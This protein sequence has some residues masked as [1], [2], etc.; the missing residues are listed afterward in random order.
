MC[1][2]TVVRRS[3]AL[4]LVVL[5]GCPKPDQTTTEPGGEP[6]GA[7]L[8]A[9]AGP[10]RRVSSRDHV[11]LDG[12]RSRG[13]SGAATWAWTQ[14]SGP[15]VAL[16]R[17]DSSRAEF[18]APEVTT[19]RVILTFELTLRDGAATA[20]TAC[21]VEVEPRTDS[22]GLTSSDLIRSAVDRGDLEPDTGIEY[23][24]FAVVGDA[25]LPAAYRGTNDRS[26]TAS[27]ARIRDEY[28]WLSSAA[29]SVVRPFLLPPSDPESWYAQ[30]TARNT[31]GPARAAAPPSTQGFVKV[32]G[33]HLNVWYDANIPDGATLAN[34]VQYE[35]ST[36][37]WRALEQLWAPD[38]RPLQDAG[39]VGDDDQIDVFLIST[40]ATT[41]NGWFSSLRAAPTPGF[42]VLTVQ[43]SPSGSLSSLG[44]AATLVHEL[45]HACQYSY[46]GMT[47]EL[48]MFIIEGTATWAKDFVYPR[49]DSTLW[50]AASAYFTDSRQYP[51]L[52]KG[53]STYGFYVLFKYMASVESPDFVRRAV[54][55]LAAAKAFDSAGAFARAFDPSVS[56]EER[57]GDFLVAAWNGDDTGY[58]RRDGL[59]VG[60]AP[61]TR[62]L[63]ANARQQAGL[64][65]TEFP[66]AIINSF[67]SV[68]IELSFDPGIRAVVFL[69]GLQ[70]ESF[71][72][73]DDNGTVGFSFRPLTP[74]ASEGVVTRVLD[75]NSGYWQERSLKPPEPA[76]LFC[77]EDPDQPTDAVG[78]IFG[79]ASRKDTIVEAR[80]HPPA[81]W[82]TNIGCYQ[83]QG[84]VTGEAR[85]GG[86]VFRTT[87]DVVFTRS[88]TN[89][90][91]D[92][93]L[94][95][96]LQ[97]AKVQWSIE[98]TDDAGCVHSGHD[99][100]TF[101]SPQS[102]GLEIAIN[103]VSGPDHRRYWING[104]EITA[105]YTTTC[106][107]SP[108]PAA[109]TL[110]WG[111]G[112]GILGSDGTKMVDIGQMNLEWSFSWKLSAKS[113]R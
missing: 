20:T 19:G 103:T 108:S 23:L 107:G 30:R 14:A 85:D 101:Q 6:A 45:T 46:A 66:D 9:N 105:V 99:A 57:W 72:Y 104:G 73:Q 34:D 8:V 98:G 42:I 63:G 22:A 97:S 29:Q 75:Y 39:V 35:V 40:I 41:V 71:M 5:L 38:H 65:K 82:A 91:R 21:S 37:I 69:D 47:N 51:P 53:D 79:N 61:S 64:G 33:S 4:A 70:F 49:V 58:F 111:W 59:T 86:V 32:P 90:Y 15:P 7:Q 2:Q 112:L 94:R 68:P 113:G 89:Y 80:G 48:A 78:L 106:D 25:R 67:S 17:A 54:A 92:A 50:K 83:W 77:L 3:C 56:V 16:A 18:D 76:T 12:S 102:G 31:P 62:L 10:P 87:S 44:L 109:K 110:P 43:P 84:T 95:F 74:N 93:P 60:L 28:P 55:E 88:P 81:I 13:Q 1:L 24:A 52:L 96:T 11:R 27:F 100:Q 26:A 36:K